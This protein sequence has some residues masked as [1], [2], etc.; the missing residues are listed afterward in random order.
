M[1]IS[2][3][4][5]DEST[6]EFTLNTLN[7][8]YKVDLVSPLLTSSL[9]SNRMFVVVDYQP[10]TQLTAQTSYRDLKLEMRTGKTAEGRQFFV[11]MWREGEKNINYDLDVQYQEVN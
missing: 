4:E 6:L 7:S 2:D 11:E 1:L 3:C 9:G 5:D 8:P 10:G